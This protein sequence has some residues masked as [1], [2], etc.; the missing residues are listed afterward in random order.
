MLIIIHNLWKYIF[1]IVELWSRY[2]D[3]NIAGKYCYIIHPAMSLEII[4]SGI[5]IFL[6][7]FAGFDGRSFNAF[8]HGRTE[9]VVFHLIQSRNGTTFW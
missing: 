9:T 5:L 4:L 7:Q 8:N 2:L 1:W 6:I 3:C